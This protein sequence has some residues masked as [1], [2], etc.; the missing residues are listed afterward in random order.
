MNGMQ[1]R[2]SMFVLIGLALL[3]IGI[4]QPPLRC[5]R[6]FLILGSLPMIAVG[7]AIPLAPPGY[8]DSLIGLLGLTALGLTAMLM[9]RHLRRNSQPAEGADHVGH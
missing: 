7:L 9:H 2:G 5:P 6:N 8:Y 4:A 3:V 1:L